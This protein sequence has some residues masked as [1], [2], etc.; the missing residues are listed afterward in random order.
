MAIGVGFANEYDEKSVEDYYEEELADAHVGAGGFVTD[1]C[2]EK[3]IERYEINKETQLNMVKLPI[4][5]EGYAEY[6]NSM[7][8][9]A[10][11]DD[12]EQ[13]HRD[14]DYL[15]VGFLKEIGCSELAKAFLDVKRWYS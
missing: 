4:D 6:V 12:G 13:A 9:C 3:A 10:K 15:L 7:R 1:I 14:A 11:N 8:E 5:H 2:Y